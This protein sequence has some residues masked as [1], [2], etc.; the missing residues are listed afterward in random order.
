MWLP[1]EGL[2]TLHKGTSAITVQLRA[3]GH[4]PSWQFQE[5]DLWPWREIWVAYHSICCGIMMSSKVMFL[6]FPLPVVK[7]EELHELL[8]RCLSTWAF[9]ESED[10]RTKKLSNWIYLFL[11]NIEMEAL[12]D[13]VVL[14]RQ[15][16]SGGDLL[17]CSSPVFLLLRSRAGR[18]FIVQGR[19]YCSPRI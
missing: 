13:A 12:R 6:N 8:L 10:G 7:K 3:V 2:L 1:W 11:T 17:E 14:I 4:H 9:H 5:C 15:W 16:I 18:I 19:R